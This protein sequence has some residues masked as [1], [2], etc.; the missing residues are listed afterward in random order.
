MMNKL[1]K[2]FLIEKN[3]FKTVISIALPI[4]MQNVISTGVN[5]MDSIMLGSL[6]NIAVSGA[7]LG[8]QTFFLL[9]IMG[10]GISGGGSV[11]ISQ[12]WGKGQTDVIKRL[13]RISMIAILIVSTVFTIGGFFFPT[14]ILSMFSHEPEVIAAGAS[15]LK[16]LSIGFIFY[17]LSNCY[18]MSIRAVE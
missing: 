14:Q 13:M 2:H 4:A 8:G 12:Y 18:M 6:G 15:Y 7:N 17:S 3:F 10:F 1:N 11:L 16:I 9:M 5:A